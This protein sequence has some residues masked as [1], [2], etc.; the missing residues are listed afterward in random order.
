GSMPRSHLPVPRG[1]IMA[2]AQQQINTVRERVNTLLMS[3]AAQ[4]IDFTIE[5]IHVDGWGF[6]YIALAM[7]TRP[8]GSH[9]TT[10]RLGHVQPGADAT[11]DPARNIFDFPNAGYGTT[12]FQKAG[13]IHECVHA[14]RDS[15]GRGI[16]TIPAQGRP[17]RTRTTALTDEAAAYIAESL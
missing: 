7:L 10:V 9:G 14:V 16:L 15:M 3:D 12:P 5:Q 11:Y 8:H 2:T 17:T 6:T 13:V 4:K 1:P